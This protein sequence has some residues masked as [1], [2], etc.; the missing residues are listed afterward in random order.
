MLHNQHQQPVELA[1]TT[2]RRRIARLNLTV[3]AFCHYLRTHHLH[4]FHSPLV[5]AA[6][7]EA[8][9]YT[10]AHD[11]KK[12]LE[13]R[14][15]PGELAAFGELVSYLGHVRVPQ[16]KRLGLPPV[17]D[18]QL[19]PHYI[20]DGKPTALESMRI[21]GHYMPL[22]SG[23]GEPTLVDCFLRRL[24]FTAKP[25]KDSDQ[26]TYEVDR[27]V[28]MNTLNLLIPQS[29]IVVR[30]QLLAGTE[31]RI[32]EPEYYTRRHCTRPWKRLD[33]NKNTLGGDIVEGRRT[34][35]FDLAMSATHYRSRVLCTRRQNRSVLGEYFRA[36]QPNLS[37]DEFPLDFLSTLGH[38]ESL[39]TFS[40][41]YRRIQ[42]HLSPHLATHQARSAETYWSI[43]SLGNPLSKAL[44]EAFTTHDST[45]I[46]HPITE[47]DPH[48]SGRSL[49]VLTSLGM[50]HYRG[51]G[52]PIGTGAYRYHL[53]ASRPGSVGWQP[54]PI[55]PTM[56]CSTAP[57]EIL[58]R[59]RLQDVAPEQRAAGY[60]QRVA[61]R[62][63]NQAIR[64][65]GGTPTKAPSKHCVELFTVPH[66]NLQSWSPRHPTGDPSDRRYHNQWQYTDPYI[67]PSS[68]LL[69]LL[70]P[71]TRLKSLGVPDT[72]MHPALRKK[73]IVPQ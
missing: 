71:T 52:L 53:D 11:V 50:K 23:Q 62:R 8:V 22:F 49:D 32:V 66:C 29:S 68:P 51:I 9:A 5:G 72:V 30:H 55:T 44:F 63:H 1:L 13:V 73:V 2:R 61:T 54:P 4:P 28:A 12:R 37:Y 17:V 21:N 38:D 39:T 18:P 31:D 47:W 10:L 41:I 20:R 6:D 19:T 56:M 48:E 70:D 16:P 33:L 35:D 42:E 64:S 24:C 36:M 45:K 57:V 69:S 60:Q 46:V 67:E 14:V 7:F 58:M 27:F 59:V 40:A 25:G 3:L 15:M 65:Q 34:M 26:R 43:P